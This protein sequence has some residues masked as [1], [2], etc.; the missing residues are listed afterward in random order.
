MKKGIT[1]REEL[2]KAIRGLKLNPVL[3]ADIIK[4]LPKEEKKKIALVCDH[5]GYWPGKNM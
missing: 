2:K 3:T 5:M 4:V 1:G